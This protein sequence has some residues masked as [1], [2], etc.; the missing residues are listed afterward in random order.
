MKL[1]I[2]NIIRFMLHAEKFKGFYSQMLITLPLVSQAGNT[3][4]VL[5]PTTCGDPSGMG[6]IDFCTRYCTVYRFKLSAVKQRIYI[7]P[8]L[9]REL[10]TS[11]QVQALHR[12]QQLAVRTYFSSNS[13]TIW[14]P[15]GTNLGQRIC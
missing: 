12:E 11:I 10:S 7:C 1:Y 9:S 15:V 3:H 14:L 8:D 4:R 13:Q 5:S 6:Y 2:I